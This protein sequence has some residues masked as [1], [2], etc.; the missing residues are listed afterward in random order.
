[1]SE[2]E[3]IKKEKKEIKENKELVLFENSQIRRQMYNGE[4]NYSIVDVIS[5]LIEQPDYQKSRKYWNKLKERLKNEEFSEVVTNCHQLKMIAK[6]GKNRNTDCA[7]RETIF[8][9]IQS[10]PSPN[11]EPFKLWFA[12][13]AEE[14][15]QEIIDPSLAIERARKTYLRKGYDEEWTNAR[16]KGIGARNEL[17]NEW[18]NRGASTTDYAILTDEISKGTFN[19]TTQQH[20][21]LKGLD[22]QNLRDN[23]SA[24]ELALMTL[25]EVTTTEIHKNNNSQGLNELEQDAKTGGGIAGQTRKNIEKQLGKPVVTSENAKDF[26][27][28]KKL[29]TPN[30][31]KKLK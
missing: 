13:L 11:A 31:K 28:P 18:K 7:N 3:L 2:N 8:R 5:I 23:M 15:I 4:W 29:K 21:D 6:D 30:N 26:R 17:T 27:K 22:K 12:K 14:R 25:A 9:L 16:I 10:V 24:L 20:K 1:M 19:I